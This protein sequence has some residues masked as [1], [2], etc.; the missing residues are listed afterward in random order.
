MPTHSP[1]LAVG[2]EVGLDQP[3]APHMCQRYRNGHAEIEALCK[4]P[5]G[6]EDCV[7]SQSLCGGARAVQLV[8]EDYGDLV[9]CLE[10]IVEK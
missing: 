10:I 5:H 9:A 1:A 8:A 7:V 4:A 3:L 6:Q 2:A